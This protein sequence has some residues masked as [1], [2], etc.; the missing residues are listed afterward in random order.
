MPF[1][2]LKISPWAIHKQKWSV[3]TKCSLCK[4]RQHVVLVRGKLPADILFVSDA[5]GSSE[6]VIGKPMVG[7]A[8][9]LL[10][11]IIE[12]AIKGRFDYCITNLIGCIPP[13]DGKK[14]AEP[15]E[16]AIKACAPRLQEVVDMCRPLLI[17][18]LGKIAGKHLPKRL[19]TN[20]QR[21]EISHPGFIHVSDVSKQALLVQQSIVAIEDAIAELVPF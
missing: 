12:R 7:P 4:T 16:E 5:P 10:D 11:H 15:T 20:C 3:C 1:K 13:K 19:P 2:G 6:D 21:I 9:H 14:V 8:G 18:C 17:I